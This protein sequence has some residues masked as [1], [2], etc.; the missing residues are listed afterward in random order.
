VHEAEITPMAS[1][2]QGEFQT[3]SQK[4]SGWSNK[5][6]Q[7]TKEVGMIIRHVPQ[8]GAA[9]YLYGMKTSTAL[10]IGGRIDEPCS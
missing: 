3:K 5:F 10:K 2:P 1:H 9:R 6:C 7:N 4:S 8:F